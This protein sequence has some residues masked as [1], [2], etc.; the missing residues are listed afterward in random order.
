MRRVFSKWDV[1]RKSC[2]RMIEDHAGGGARATRA[3]LPMQNVPKIRLRMS[4]VVVAP[5][6]S[7]SARRAA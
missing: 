4:S 5:V 7:S 3:Y 1:A 6:I 2:E